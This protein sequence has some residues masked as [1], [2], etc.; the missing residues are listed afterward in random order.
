[1]MKHII[2]QTSSLLKSI[3]VCDY[4]IMYLPMLVLMESQLI[5]VTMGR[6]LKTGFCK[7]QSKEQNSWVTGDTY[8]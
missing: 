5:H 7:A 3:A 4:V 1:M 6:H 2:I 8:S